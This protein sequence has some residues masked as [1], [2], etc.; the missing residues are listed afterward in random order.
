MRVGAPED[1][2]S[3][4]LAAGGVLLTTGDGLGPQRIAGECTRRAALGQVT[5]SWPEEAYGLAREHGAL[6]VG[7]LVDDRPEGPLLRLI[8]LT[9]PVPFRTFRAAYE[10]LW[11][12]RPETWQF[13]DELGALEAAP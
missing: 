9:G 13:W 2:P 6:L 12:R 8:D 11:C 1:A 5:V 7:L 4:V 10:A 3:A